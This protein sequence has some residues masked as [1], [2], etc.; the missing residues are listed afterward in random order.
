[1]PTIMT[2]VDERRRF[3]VP[4]PF[5][6]LVAR[7]VLLLLAAFLLFAATRCQPEPVP[8]PAKLFRVPA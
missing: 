2:L 3:I 8:L 5:D 6:R 7:L 4:S 1:M